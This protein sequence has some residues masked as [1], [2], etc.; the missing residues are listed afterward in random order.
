MKATI[1]FASF[2]IL[3]FIFTF[4]TVNAEDKGFSSDTTEISIG[5]GVDIFADD[6]FTA[7][8]ILEGSEL[9]E[10]SQGSSQIDEAEMNK[11]LMTGSGVSLMLGMVVVPLTNKRR[12]T[13]ML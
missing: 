5:A 1:F 2:I 13:P 8:E 9:N 11:I 10:R 12:R 4:N 7:T 3:I 6:N